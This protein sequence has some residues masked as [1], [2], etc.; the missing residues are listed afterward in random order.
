MDSRG[1]RRLHCLHRPA[2]GVSLEHEDVYLKELS[3]R[4]ERGTC[5]LGRS[6][7]ATPMAALLGR[8]TARG[9]IS[10]GGSCSKP[11]THWAQLDA[12]RTR[13]RPGETAQWSWTRASPTA[14]KYPSMARTTRVVIG[15]AVRSRRR[16]ELPS[17]R[18]SSGIAE[19]TLD[20]TPNA[21][22]ADHTRI[23]GQRWIRLAGQ[24]RCRPPSAIMWRLGQKQKPL[25][26]LFSHRSD[27]RHRR[28]SRLARSRPAVFG[29]GTRLSKHVDL[30]WSECYFDQ[31]HSVPPTFG[32]RCQ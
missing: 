24:A 32:E 20:G 31:S 28:C 14:G 26:G 11:F 6:A 1:V 7:I 22:R 5:W 19:L 30:H 21:H 27:W 23:R 15:R 10:F 8:R 29:T 13:Q 17:E 2:W 16:D 18:R 3:S 12:L 4:A 9:G 25:L